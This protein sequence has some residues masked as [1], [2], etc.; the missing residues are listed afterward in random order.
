M[1]FLGR[2]LHTNEPPKFVAEIGPITAS[3]T[4]ADPFKRVYEAY[5]ANADYIK[6]Q[7]Y[8][9]DEIIKLRGR[10]ALKN[11]KFANQDPHKFYAKY[12]ADFETIEEVFSYAAKM[13]MPIFSSVFGTE[14]LEKL[15]KLHCPAYKIAARDAH[16]RELFDAVASTLKP[17]IISVPNDFTPQQHADLRD[18]IEDAGNETIIMHCVSKY[19]TQPKEADMANFCNIQAMY[20]GLPDNKTEYGYSDHTPGWSA[21]IIAMV[22]GATIIEKHFSLSNYKET[23]EADDLQ[24]ARM[25][26]ECHRMHEYI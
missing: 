2:K 6:I 11:T 25:V 13:S 1:L 4:K 24:F 7:A 8:T 23:Y 17:M 20:G 15:E 5:H 26:E 9:A 3:V 16:Q 19:P 10:D 12:E 21:A 18:R 14:T 22:M